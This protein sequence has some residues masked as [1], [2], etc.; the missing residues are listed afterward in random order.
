MEGSR[1]GWCVDEG[2]HIATTAVL[3]ESQGVA[4]P[5]SA[6]TGLDSKI[7]AMLQKEIHS[8][9]DFPIEPGSRV[10]LRAGKITFEA[11]AQIPTA[12]PGTS[13]NGDIVYLNTC[14]AVSC[15]VNNQI[16]PHH[17]TIFQFAGICI[18]SKVY[19]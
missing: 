12:A 19:T 17:K 10:I 3:V 9:G 16:I 18:V 13:K 5:C 2:P 8:R 7:Q 6:G 11:V 15:P 14:I 1:G 4:F